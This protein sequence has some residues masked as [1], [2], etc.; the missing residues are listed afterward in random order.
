MRVAIFA[1]LLLAASSLAHICT[2]SS[3][4]P[5][6][7]VATWNIAQDN[8]TTGEAERLTG[9]INV[10]RVADFDVVCLQE[11][12]NSGSRSTLIDQLSSTYPHSFFAPSDSDI[13][14]NNGQSGN[15]I[16]S[17]LPLDSTDFLRL[18]ETTSSADTV[19][20]ARMDGVYFFCTRL[21]SSVADEE[22]TDLFAFVDDKTSGANPAAVIVAGDIAAGPAIPNGAAINNAVYQRYVSSPENFI[23]AFVDFRDQNPNCTVCTS[24]SLVPASSESTLPDHVFF[25]TTNG[26]CIITSNRFALTETATV[27]SQTIPLSTHFGVVADLCIPDFSSTTNAGTTAAVVTTGNIIVAT[28]GAT[29]DRPGHHCG[30][31]IP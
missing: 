19:L 7:R 5:R 18:N 30:G 25:L 23:S 15:V 10:L 17:K 3:C 28:T 14:A 2:D 11:V 27:D 13:S 20:F 8:A 31:W 12:F 26:V 16:L 4:T 6:L 21:S 29:T 9:T 1:L 22:S 24:N